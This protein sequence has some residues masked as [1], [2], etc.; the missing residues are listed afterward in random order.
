MIILNG[1]L[2]ADLQMEK[3]AAYVRE[4]EGT[5]ANKYERCGARDLLPHISCAFQYVVG[6]DQSVRALCDDFFVNSCFYSLFVK[7][8]SQYRT[9]R[10]IVLSLTACSACVTAGLPVLRSSKHRP[11]SSRRYVLASLALLYSLHMVLCLNR[12]SYEMRYPQ[13]YSLP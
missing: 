12:I 11:Q 9:Q 7:I 4:L 1:V 3:L 5:N 2:C 13:T 6:T 10:G 8:L